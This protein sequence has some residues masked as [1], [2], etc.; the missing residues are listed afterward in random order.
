MSEVETELRD[1]LRQKAQEIDLEPEVPTPLLRRARRRRAGVAVLAG[2]VAAALLLGGLVGARAAMELLSTEDT[3]PGIGPEPSAA[4]EPWRGVW[5]Q[6]SRRVAEVAQ[7]NADAG[8]HDAEWQL[9]AD[10]VVRTYAAEVL[11]W[12]RVFFDET[13]DDLDPDEPGPLAVRIGT[14]SGLGTE[15]CPEEARVTIERLLRRD[16][17]G[18]WFVTDV[19]VEML[20]RPGLEERRRAREERRQREAVARQR[21][22]AGA[23]AF[24]GSFVDA[25]IAGSGAE[26]FLSPEGKAAFD[27]HANDLYLY[28]NPHPAGDPSAS[29]TR[30]E[31]VALEAVDANAFEATVRIYAEYLG[32]SDPRWLTERLFIGPGEDLQGRSRDLI[33]RGAVRLA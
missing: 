33:V 11:G 18:I 2:S 31:I 12:D 1:L 20:A 32:D 29:Y 10:D 13:L 5:P 7:A 8:L 25:R 15:Q 17:T 19:E 30:Y 27:R 23:S 22:L 26:A 16:R 24:V 28:G 6:A 21:R 14:C 9:L 4:E 3:R